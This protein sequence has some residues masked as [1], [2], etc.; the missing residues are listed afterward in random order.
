MGGATA[1]AVEMLERQFDLVVREGDGS[2]A[3]LIQLRRWLRLVEAEPSARPHLA[4]MRRE[5]GQS[6]DT[7]ERQRH[8]LRPRL[9]ELRRRL[10]ELAPHLEERAAQR[11]P[12]GDETRNLSWFSSLGAIDAL[13]AGEPLGGKYVTAEHSDSSAFRKMLLLLHKNL[14]DVDP[15]DQAAHLAPLRAELT[16]LFEVYEKHWRDHLDAVRRSPS[17]ALFFVEDVLALLNPDARTGD[18]RPSRLDQVAEHFESI[19]RSSLPGQIQ[20]L[21]AC[22]YSGRKADETDRA[23]VQRLVRSATWVKDE[24]VRRIGTRVSLVETMR[25]YRLR[26]ELFDQAR[27]MRLV[28]QEQRAAATEG[29]K[30]RIEAVLQDELALWLSDQGLDVYTEKRLGNLRAD[31]VVPGALYIEAKQYGGSFKRAKLVG[32]LRQALDTFRRERAQHPELDEGFVVVFRHGGPLVEVDEPLP[33]EDG[34][35]LHFLLVDLAEDEVGSGAKKPAA[36]ISL[37]EVREAA[38]P[39]LD[40]GDDEGAPPSPPARAPTTAK[41]PRATRP[42]RAAASSAKAP[43]PAPTAA[44]APRGPASAGA[45]RRG[46]ARTKGRRK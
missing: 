15:L 42:A 3:A 18:A 19:T 9:L 38:P 43:A 20:S 4:Q 30:A 7:I 31:I 46:R 27:L 34:G 32:G 6:I 33:L 37:Q 10:G 1:R 25:R 44:R 5:A 2:A 36:R 12:Q 22:F 29:R 39:L 28:R 40:A 45:G 41:A 8:A 21:Q 14:Q 35:C 13:D 11:P 16:N 24:L 17:L 23:L 26:C